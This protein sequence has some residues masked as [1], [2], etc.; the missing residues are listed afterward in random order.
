MVGVVYLEGRKL[1]LLLGL[2]VELVLFC[3]LYGGLLEGGE[4]RMIL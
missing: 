2:F 1:V 3:L 4:E